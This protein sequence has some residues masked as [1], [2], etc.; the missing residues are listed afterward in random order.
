MFHATVQGIP[1]LAKDGYPRA[2]DSEGVPLEEGEV[3]DPSQ[4]G[5]SIDLMLPAVLGGNPYVPG[6][7]PLTTWR[8]QIDNR[9]PSQGGVLT[10]YLLPRVTEIESQANPNA[11]GAEAYGWLPPPLMGEGLKVQ[12]GWLHDFLLEPYTIRPATF[13]RMPK[14]NMSKAEASQLVN[15][16]AAYDNAD[17]PY[18][19][20]DATN[21]SSLAMKNAEYRRSLQE[22]GQEPAARFDDAMRIVVDNNFCV[23]CHLV[24]DFEPQGSVRA[25][26]PNLADVY[27][28]LRPE[29]VRDWIANPKMILPYTP[30]P[31]NIPYKTGDRNLGGVSQNLYHGTSIEQLDGLVDLLMNYDKY[32]R[33]QT[34]ISDL[35]KP[36]TGGDQ[37]PAQT[38]TDQKTTQTSTSGAR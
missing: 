10:K 14:F 4:V 35:V 25:K 23:K 12:P 28:R 24:G 37:P 38:S 20:S 1:A 22:A 17:Y 11:N 27:R 34:R 21:E 2:V 33:E 8:R 9:Y 13:L 36:A 15:Y 18:E 7:S 30:M 16:F 26:A 19:S 32:T 3:Y 29:Y 5:F 6:Q 31:V